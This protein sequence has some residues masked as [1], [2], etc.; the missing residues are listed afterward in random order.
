MNRTIYPT[1]TCFDD[2]LDFFEHVEPKT[3]PAYRVVHGLA[4]DDEGQLFAHAWIE[5][6]PDL[7]WQGGIIGGRRCYYAMPCDDFY[8]WMGVVRTSRY[9]A[10]LAA[11]LNA[12][13]G[14]YGPWRKEY[15]ALCGGAGRITKRK[16]PDYPLRAFYVE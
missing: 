11:Q 16:Q 3:F 1:H 12:S 15:A 8:R 9:S 5:E 13:T 2:A 10:Q 14:H 6:T 7:V 4:T